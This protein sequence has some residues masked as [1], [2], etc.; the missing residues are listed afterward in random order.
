[1]R[2]EITRRDFV[3]I[4]PGRLSIIMDKCDQNILVE[5]GVRA[6]SITP[7]A[8]TLF[9]TRDAPNPSYEKVKCFRTYVAKM[10]HFA[11]RLESPYLVTVAFLTNRV[12]EVGVDDITKLKRV[13]GYLCRDAA[14]RDYITHRRSH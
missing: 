1:M 12:N 3:F 8:A 2:V 9:E 5:C 14:P 6:L 7:T 13:F 10:L 4:L 11:Q